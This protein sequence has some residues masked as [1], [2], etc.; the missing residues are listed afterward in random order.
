M[1]TQPPMG[2]DAVL[3]V[4]G[5]DLLFLVGFLGSRRLML[6]YLALMAVD[7]FYLRLESLHLLHRLHVGKSQREEDGVDDN[8][9]HHDGPAE[10][11]D[12]SAVK[13]VD[14][15]EQRLGE[16]GQAA[17][18]HHLSSLGLMRFSRSTSLGRRTAQTGWVERRRRVSGE[19]AGFS[20]N[21][22]RTVSLRV[23]SCM[24]A[25]PSGR[26]TAAK[27]L[28]A[29][30]PNEKLPLAVTGP[31]LAALALCSMSL[32]CATSK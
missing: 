29:I 21:D 26:K 1:G 6:L 30:P 12:E 5:H 8:G 32:F 24:A 16:E 25:L 7:F 15:E 19:G 14:D 11:V 27:N 2:V 9:D 31:F 3:L 17:E 4:K 13:P 20:S 10:V 23:A 18:I 28:S 22:V